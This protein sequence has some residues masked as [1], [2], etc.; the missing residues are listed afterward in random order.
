MA[1]LR[2]LLMSGF[3]AKTLHVVLEGVESL[4]LEVEVVARVPTSGQKLT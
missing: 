3:E 1:V 2:R 4:L